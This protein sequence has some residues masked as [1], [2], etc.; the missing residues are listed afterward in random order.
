MNAKIVT[1]KKKNINKVQLICCILLLGM[2][3]A[4]RLALQA[5]LS[6]CS[7]QLSVARKVRAQEQLQEVG[8]EGH[9]D[10]DAVCVSGRIFGWGLHS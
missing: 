2:I 10:W 9:R 5:L 1:L 3:G 8:A 4:P 6:P 7:K